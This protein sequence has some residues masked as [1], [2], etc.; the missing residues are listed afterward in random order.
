MDVILFLLHMLVWTLNKI[1]NL[2]K[3][4]TLELNSRYS[5]ELNVTDFKVRNINYLDK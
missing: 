3:K 4:V 5:I 1:P 2:N